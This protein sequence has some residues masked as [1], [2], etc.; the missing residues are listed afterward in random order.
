MGRNFNN[1]FLVASARG[2]MQS[3]TA[4]P[5]LLSPRELFSHCSR[6]RADDNT[7]RRDFISANA[8]ALIHRGQRRDA[9]ERAR[10][11]T[12]R[13]H[14]NECA[15]GE[16]EAGQNE[17]GDEIRISA[18]IFRRRACKKISNRLSTHPLPPTLPFSLSLSPSIFPSCSPNDSRVLDMC[19]CT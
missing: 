15:R 6:S 4:S 9:G 16:R 3:S 8:D 12:I 7:I 1:S 11:L 10:A 17:D 13:I 14:M 5:A 18:Q 2:G 19:V